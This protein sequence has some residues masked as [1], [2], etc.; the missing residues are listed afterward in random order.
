MSALVVVVSCS[1]DGTRPEE[2][3][4][5]TVVGDDA[6]YVVEPVEFDCPSNASCNEQI[7]VGQNSYV[8]PY[9]QNR[10]FHPEAVS[11]D[12]YAVGGDGTEEFIEIRTLVGVPT[13]Y[14]LAARM[15]GTEDWV[16]VG[17]QPV[18]GTEMEDEPELAETICGALKDR[19]VGW[20]FCSQH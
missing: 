20:S 9:D 1:S 11:D 6:V 3:S 18:E 7:W 8:Y 5:T 13:E 14:A 4:A 15:T 12:V 17:G 2:E 10:T 19:E 16:A